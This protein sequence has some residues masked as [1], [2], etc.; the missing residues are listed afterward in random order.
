ML[1]LLEHSTSYQ[2]IYDFLQNRPQVEAEEIYKRV[3]GGADAESVLRHVQEGDLLVQLAVVPETRYRY[4]FPFIREMPSYLNRP[5]NPY[6]DSL[7][8][9]WTAAINGVSNPQRPSSV[10]GAVVHQSLYLEPYHAADIIDPRISAVKPSDWTSVSSDDGLMRK[11]LASYFMT[12][13][14]WLTFFH[15]DYFLEDMVA[16]RHRFCSPLLVNALFACVCVC[17]LVSSW[18]SVADCLG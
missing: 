4:E 7:I 18:R 2:Q 6:L 3:R 16:K 13:Y 12:E 17:P 1:N 9:E 5:N 10:S 11:L 8:Y 15:K 14:H